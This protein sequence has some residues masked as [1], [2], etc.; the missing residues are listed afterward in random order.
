[1]IERVWQD[2]SYGA[3]SLWKTP[4]FAVIAV[5]TLALGI[6]ANTAI[7]SLIDAILLRWLP[8]RDPQE[9]IQVIIRRPSSESLIPF[10]AA[11]GSTSSPRTPH[12]L[13]SSSNTSCCMETR[14]P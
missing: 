1:M 10:K 7:F 4:A 13:Y 2:I 14:S 11:S 6:G 3:R 12:A 9:L 8:V 5:L